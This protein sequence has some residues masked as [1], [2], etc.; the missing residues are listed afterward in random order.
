M[1]N[2]GSRTEPCGAPECFPESYKVVKKSTNAL[3][4]LMC[5][6]VWY[7]IF[8]GQCSIPFSI[9]INAFGQISIKIAMYMD[10]TGH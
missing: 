2:K 1:N 10:H 5:Y 9:N 6:K 3:F 8:C 4:N 7:T